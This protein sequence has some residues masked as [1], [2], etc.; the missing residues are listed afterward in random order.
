MIETSI[1]FF[2]PLSRT[3]FNR[4]IWFELE[5]QSNFEHEKDKKEVSLV[6]NVEGMF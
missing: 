4:S 1:L 2:T 3:I 5:S 6:M